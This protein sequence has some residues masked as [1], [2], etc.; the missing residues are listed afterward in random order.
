MADVYSVLAASY[1]LL[2]I[3]YA[4]AALV[5]YAGHR[6]RALSPD[7][8]VAAFLVG[9][10]VFG[11]GGLGC[12]ILLVLFFASSSLLSFFKA[13]DARKR[14]AADTFEKGGRRDAAQVLANGALASVASLLLGVTAGSN[15]ELLFFGALVG[16]FAAATADTWA[17][18]IGVLSASDPRLVT[19]GKQ[20]PAGTSGGITWLGSVAAMTGAGL[21]GIVGALLSLVS[22]VPSA[23][24]PALIVAGLLGGTAGMLADSLLGA[25]VQASYRCPR[26]DKPTESRVHRCGTTAELV[27]GLPWVNNDFV[28]VA[29]TLVGGTVGGLT[30]LALGI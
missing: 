22:L 1:S 14:Q 26:C 2:L 3:A 5:A 30:L 10:A 11:F 4:V 21:I 24:P 23:S 19:T 29:A 16:A 20:V 28:N 8:A 18:E 6:A 17:T 12:A 7:G 13:G 15:L 9:G 27:R 25:T